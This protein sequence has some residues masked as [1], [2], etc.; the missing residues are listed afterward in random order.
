MYS[1][2]AFGRVTLGGIAMS[3]L[4]TAGLLNGANAQSRID[5]TVNGVRL[6]MG[7]GSLNPL[8]PI[9][10]G[11]DVID[12]VVKLCVECG[13][14]YI[15]LVNGLIEPQFAGIGGGGRIP[16]PLTPD[17]IE[18]RPKLREWR[19]NAPISRFEEVKRKFDAAGLKLVSYVMTFTSDFS[20]EEIDAVFRHADALGVEFISTNQSK[21]STG[22]RVAPFAAR[23]RAKPSWHNHARIDDWDEVASL[24][25]FDELLSMSPHFMANLDIGHFTAGNQDS[26][27]FLQKHHARISHIHVKDRKRDNGPNHPWGQGDTPI[28]PVLRLIKENRWPIYVIQEREYRG[29]TAGDP[30]SEVK[31]NIA[32]MHQALV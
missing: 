4:M 16:D 26:V 18:N 11:E 27:A 12:T 29:P 32:Y 23:Y 10:P 30:I 19:I 20:M 21:V 6:G 7:T 5:S 8:P 22:R 17:W 24:E 9:P 14:G 15:E 1:R 25:S 13:M 3:S 28:I 31:K 2:R